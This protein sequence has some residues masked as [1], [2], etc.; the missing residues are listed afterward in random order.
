MIKAQEKYT[1]DQSLGALLYEARFA[2]GESIETI[3]KKL[4]IQPKFLEAMEKGDYSQF[5]GQ[6]FAIG[7]LKTYAFYL[8]LHADD[9][10]QLLN[11][12]FKGSS[13]TQE[14]HFP[15]ITHERIFPSKKIVYFSVLILMLLGVSFSFEKEPISEMDVNTTEPIEQQPSIS[16]KKEVL[17]HETHHQTVYAE[18]KALGK[19]WIE[20][21]HK[22]KG[23]VFDKM[24]QVGEKFPITFVQGNSLKIG[25]AA[26]IEVL[27]DGVT[28]GSLGQT[29][30]VISGIPL[31]TPEAFKEY[32]RQR[33]TY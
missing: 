7:F 20:I 14:L 23:I 28:S 32:M 33:I 31:D 10:I 30:D 3:S 12:G 6:P 16:T 26:G 4:R 2:K 25:N 1:K 5:P 13:Q 9:L 21:R 11:E 19:C 15:K 24:L 22:E 29:G 17:S 27:I 8:D 18:L